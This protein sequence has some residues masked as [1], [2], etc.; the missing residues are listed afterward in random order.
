MLHTKFEFGAVC[1]GRQRNVLRCIKHKHSDCFFIINSL[2][3]SGILVAVAAI[4][5][6]KHILKCFQQYFQCRFIKSFQTD[7]IKFLNQNRKVF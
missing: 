1:R 2:A 6:S 7:V 3:V 5:V 4:V